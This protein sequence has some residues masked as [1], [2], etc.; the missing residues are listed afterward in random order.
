MP[1]QP[2]DVTPPKVSFT[3]DKIFKHFSGIRDDILGIC[4]LLKYGNHVLFMQD[5]KTRERNLIHTRDV[6][7]Q[8][9]ERAAVAAAAST[10][11]TTTAPPVGGGGS[12]D[13]HAVWGLYGL[14]NAEVQFECWSTGGWDVG[15]TWSMHLR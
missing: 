9:A 2:S 6:L 7:V 5:L 4:R 3:P 1:S 8:R 12:D 10:A 14:T 11:A 13:G 15:D